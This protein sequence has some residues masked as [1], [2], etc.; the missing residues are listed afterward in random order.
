MAGVGS[1]FL[2][3]NRPFQRV[4]SFNSRARL[5]HPANYPEHSQSQSEEADG[6]ADLRVD[7]RVIVVR[8]CDCVGGGHYR[9]ASP[10]TFPLSGSTLALG[11]VNVL[12]VPK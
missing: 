3:I 2:E 8:Q 10:H 7:L 9:A 6:R 5:Y 12:F 1:I 11:L 4:R